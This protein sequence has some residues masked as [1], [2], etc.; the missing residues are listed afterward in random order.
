LL[1]GLRFSEEESRTSP[2]YAELKKMYEGLSGGIRSSRSPVSRLRR[3]TGLGVTGSDI[4]VRRNDADVVRDAAHMEGLGDLLFIE[5][6]VIATAH[7][8]RPIPID[9][10][11]TAFD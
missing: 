6:A 3:M 8:R 10:R 5:E 1:R 4:P 11:I 2:F 9:A 7:C